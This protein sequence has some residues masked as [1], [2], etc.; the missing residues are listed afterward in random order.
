MAKILIVEDMRDG[1]KALIDKLASEGF[2][3]LEAK[4]GK[5][6]LELA[7][8]EHPDL[9]LL[10]IVVSEMGCMTMVEKLRRDK[11]GKSIPIIMFTNSNEIEKVSNVLKSGV[12][13]YLVKSDW[14]IESVV[15]R[16][17]EKLGIT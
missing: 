13:E 14:K 9:I 2:D 7:L 5:E 17:R 6:G 12:Y 3:V 8:K 4:N 16:V 15:D 1:R 10:D 11:Y